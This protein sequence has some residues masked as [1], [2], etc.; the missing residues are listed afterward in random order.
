MAYR[1]KDAVG[2]EASILRLKSTVTSN[3]SNLSTCFALVMGIVTRR[4]SSDGIFLVFSVAFN[5]FYVVKNIV[6]PLLFLV[7]LFLL[8]LEEV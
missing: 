2:I 7:N 5:H 8:F 1:K 6:F 3:A 4:G